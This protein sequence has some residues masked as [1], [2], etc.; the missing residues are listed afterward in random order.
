MAIL[1]VNIT[2]RKQVEEALRESE[3]RFRDIT[4]NAA[5]WV[6][7]VDAQGKYLYSSPVVEQLL[8]YKPEEILDKHFYDLFLP[9]QRKDLKNAALKAFAAKQPFRDFLNPNLH[10]NGQIV[11]LSTSGIPI[12]DEQ[13][14]LLG[15]RGSDIDI[16]ERREAEELSHNLIAK[17]PVGIYLMQERKFQLVNQVF[18]TITG[19]SQDEFLHLEPLDLIHPEDREATRNNAIK[20]LRGLSSAPYEYRTITKGE[21]IKWIMETLTTISYKGKRAALGYFM[22]VTERKALEGQLLQAQKM[23]AVGRLAGGVAHDFNNL[24]MAITGYGELMRAKVL[25]EDPLYG[26][27]ENILKA[28]DRAAALTRQLLTFSRQKIV[29]PQVIDLNRVVLDLEPILRRLIGEDLDLE[30]VTDLRL[31]AVKADPGQLGQIIMNLVVNARDAMPIG[32]R[33]TLKTAPVEFTE[34]RHT[35]FGLTPPGAYVMLEVQDTGVGMDEATQTHVFEPFFTTKE[36]GKGTGLGLST[37]YGIVKQSGGYLDLASEP[38]DGSTFTIYLPRLEAS[39]GAP[40]GQDPHHRQLPG[41]GND[42]A[43]GRRGRAPG[44]AGQVLAALWLHGVGGP[45]RR[46]GPVDL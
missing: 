37:V 18:F 17:S 32:G 46:R 26:Y 35:R 10:K 34:S 4:E 30:V 5:E 31:G 7:E 24:L 45:P 29:N 22:D 21:G 6:W 36:P 39:R 28:G 43:G 27:L 13:G 38:G 41:G 1:G 11:W 3:Q 44:L 9:E 19:Y 23:E 15:Y 42:S 16:T 40:Q 25:K 20:M 8:G 14:N 12:L 33:L 2:A